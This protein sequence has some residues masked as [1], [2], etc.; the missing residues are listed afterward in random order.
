MG[1]VE[2]VLADN[3][4][5][6]YRTRQHVGMLVRKAGAMLFAFVVFLAIGLAVL[7]PARNEAGNEVRF[8]VGVVA[9]GSLLL[10]VIAIIRVLLAGAR[11]RELAGQIWRPA[12]VGILILVTALFLMFQ[13][14]FR[15]IGWVAIIIAIV[16]LLFVIQAVVQWFAKQYIITSRRVMEVEGVTDK[17]I[18]DSALEKVN[19][20]E[21]DQSLLGRLLGYGHVEIITGSDIGVDEFYMIRKPVEFKRAMLN[22]KENLDTPAARAEHGGVPRGEA[23]Q[24]RSAIPELIAELALLHKEGVLSDDEFESK[25]RELLSRL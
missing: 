3:E 1:Y 11:G 18:R 12:L 17:H 20:I 21:L 13:P 6:L 2:G 4:R 25:K 22:A 19:D 10:P 9:L 15:L 8:W 5:I 7:I 24:Q 23:E 14:D 16:P